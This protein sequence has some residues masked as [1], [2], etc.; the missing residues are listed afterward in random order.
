MDNELDFL[1]FKDAE[2][3]LRNRIF[4][5]ISSMKDMIDDEEGPEYKEFILNNLKSKNKDCSVLILSDKNRKE[6]LG[7][8]CILEDDRDVGRNMEIKGLW[9]GGVN[10]NRDHR[11]KGYGSFLINNLNHHLQMIGLNR[12]LKIN[13]FSDNPIAIKLYERIGF[14]FTNLYF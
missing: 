11:G 7:I 12:N 10:I 6:P 13:L 9:I 5:W 1:N 4:D 14:I 2:E 8:A 3:N